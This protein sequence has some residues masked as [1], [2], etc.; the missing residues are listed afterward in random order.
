MENDSTGLRLFI[1]IECPDN[2]K[3]ELEKSIVQVR[4]A[5][6]RGKFSRRENLHLTLIFLGQVPASRVGEIT[7]VMD[8][9]AVPPFS[10][11]IG[12]MGRFR[13]SG[14][15]TLWRQVSADSG[16]ILLQSHLAV[17]LREKGFPLE[18][19]S[20]RPHM[21]IARR[22]VLG[23]RTRLSDLSAAMPNLSFTVDGITLMRSELLPSGPVY[24][25]LHRTLF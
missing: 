1:A 17:L 16:L 9:C 5:C 15:D 24:T 23:V 19:R 2:I 11:T 25:R 22:A 20:F 8:V 21:T 10:T 12:S 13:R 14:G 18:D 6:I 3:T 4:H 7:S